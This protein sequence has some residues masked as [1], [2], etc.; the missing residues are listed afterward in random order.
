[1]EKWPYHYVYFLNTIIKSQTSEVSKVK[2]SYLR[3]GIKTLCSEVH[4]L[5]HPVWNKKE[6]VPQQQKKCFIIAIYKKGDKTPCIQD[7][8]ISFISI[9]CIILSN[10]PVTRLTPYVDRIIWNHQHRFS[11]NRSVTGHIFCIHYILEKKWDYD[12]TV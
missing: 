10:I 7:Q 11:H 2:C 12:G 3:Q 5:I 4:R 1:L 9:S 6:V 8:G